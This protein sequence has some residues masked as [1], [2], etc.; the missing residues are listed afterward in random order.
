MICC[1]D[2]SCVLSLNT[3]RSQAWNKI[4][5]LWLR[6]PSARYRAR[7]REAFLEPQ[8]PRRLARKSQSFCA[9]K[10][11]T[12]SVG[13]L[14]APLMC[15]CVTSGLR[16]PRKMWGGNSRATYCALNPVR[17]AQGSRFAYFSRISRPPAD[18]NGS[19]TISVYIC[20][21]GFFKNIYEQ[22]CPR[23]G[24]RCATGFN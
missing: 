14:L 11:Q 7:A 10:N 18:R 23:T 6:M 19:A 24:L 15:I 13:P 5:L 9:I 3:D 1:F 4:R 17:K 12:G 20:L 21:S 2:A 22:R 16:R 8:K